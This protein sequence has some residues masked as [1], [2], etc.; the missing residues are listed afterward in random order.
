MNVARND[1]KVRDLHPKNSM[2]FD[3]PTAGLV[4]LAAGGGRLRLAVRAWLPEHPFAVVSRLY[5]CP[6]AGRE[7]R[8]S[9]S[10]VLKAAS[11]PAVQ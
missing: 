2:A 4:S 10:L 11:L 3:F 5:F 8:L 9:A 1:G 6:V 7:S